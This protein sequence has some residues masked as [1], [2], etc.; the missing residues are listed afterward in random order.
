MSHCERSQG[1]GPPVSGR[2][3]GAGAPAAIISS[4]LFATFWAASRSWVHGPVGGVALGHILG[5][6]MVDEALGQARGQHQLAVG[7]GDEA[8]AQRVE[9]ETAPRP[10]RRCAR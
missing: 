8:F 6:G 2:V 7:D 9:P 1:A 3:C 10:P 4:I 5:P